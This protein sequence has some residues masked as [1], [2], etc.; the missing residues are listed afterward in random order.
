ML[1]MFPLLQIVIPGNCQMHLQVSLSQRGKA[2]GSWNLLPHWVS[3]RASYLN[4]LSAPRQQEAALYKC[5]TLTSSSCSLLKAMTWD[6]STRMTQ[7]F[8]ISNCPTAATVTVN[9]PKVLEDL[10]S[11]P[12]GG[13]L[14]VVK[15]L[16]KVQ[17]W[18]HWPRL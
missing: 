10:H 13:H 16:G 12:T 1:A 8:A 5:S 7:V 14:G 9:P 15:T 3:C 4:D 17:A 6:H 18:F 11:S 2:P